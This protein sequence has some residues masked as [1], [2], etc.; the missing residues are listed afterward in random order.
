M[1]DNLFIIFA[2]CK[3]MQKTYLMPYVEQYEKYT[4]RT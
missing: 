2:T 3:K 1:E 4:T